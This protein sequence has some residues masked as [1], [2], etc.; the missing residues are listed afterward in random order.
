MLRLLTIGFARLRS[1]VKVGGSRNWSRLYAL[2]EKQVVW[3]RRE[4]GSS[5]PR[6][7]ALLFSNNLTFQEMTVPSIKKRATPTILKA[8]VSLTDDTHRAAEDTR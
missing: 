3:G 8:R 5:L 2:L 1:F 7:T 6:L 4:E